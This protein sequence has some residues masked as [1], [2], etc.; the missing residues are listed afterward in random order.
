MWL[1]KIALTRRIDSNEIL[2]FRHCTRVPVGH[3]NAAS[4]GMSADRRRTTRASLCCNRVARKLLV[5]RSGELSRRPWN[6]RNWSR[7]CPESAAPE[8][9]KCQ[10]TVGPPWVRHCLLV[11]AWLRLRALVG[12]CTGLDAGVRVTSLRDPPQHRGSPTQGP[13]DD[14]PSGPRCGDPKLR[15]GLC[16]SNRDERVRERCAF[17][18]EHFL[19]LAR[20]YPRGL[21]WV[22]LIKSSCLG[23]ASRDFVGSRS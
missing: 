14:G 11:L 15:P 4:P 20:S 7:C 23:S 8:A 17:G 1:A 10:R 13:L 19:P 3:L 5:G 2:G 21:P 12:V 18:H 16:H 6:P 22:Y 9:A